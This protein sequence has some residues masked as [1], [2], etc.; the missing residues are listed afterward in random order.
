MALGIWNILYFMR[1]CSWTCRFV[2]EFPLVPD[3]ICISNSFLITLLGKVPYIFLYKISVEQIV[4]N[5][6]LFFSDWKASWRPLLLFIYIYIYIWRKLQYGSNL[7]NFNSFSNSD[8]E[9]EWVGNTVFQCT[10]AYIM[11]VQHMLRSFSKH[12]H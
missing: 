4:L 3:D 5:V 8:L 9:I 7:R 12:L 1:K 10:A 6:Q 2:I 11:Y